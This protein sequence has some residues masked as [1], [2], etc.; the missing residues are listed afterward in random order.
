[1]TNEDWYGTTPAHWEAGNIRRFASMR[2]GHTPSRQHP[3]Y[4]TDCTI[5]WFTLADVWQLRAG[6]R[7]LGE[8]SEQ[9]S[10]LGLANSAAELLPAGTV[11]LSRTASV[12]FSGI[13]PVPMATSQDFWNWVPKPGMLSRFL[14]YQLQSMKPEFE[15]L[16]MGSTHRTIYQGDAASL[17]VVAPPLGEQRAIADY[18]DRETA[19]IDAFIAKNE[20]LIAL[21]TE[22]RAGVAQAGVE[23]HAGHGARLKYRFREIDVRAGGGWVD[24]PLLS[25]SIHRGVVPRDETPRFSDES[26]DLSH[27]KVA[28]LGD[29]VLNR[30]R[31][32]QGG[33]GVAPCAGLVSPDYAVLR[34]FDNVDAEW[35]AL[36]MRTP[37]FV[38][39]MVLRLRGIGSTDSGAVR[40]PRIGV[41]DVGAILID[42]PAAAVQ[43]AELQAVAASV[44]RIEAALTVARRGVELA[45][46]RR[47]A[48]I[49]A[50][51]TG[52]IDVGVAA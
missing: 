40:T 21:L 5:P 8:T 12:G 30:M 24:L 25:V 17:R 4:W 41:A 23:H 37:R 6:A 33:L 16:M 32:F 3:E 45:R 49:S 35:L 46:E 19:Q 43:R 27:Y 52:K 38:G 48:L 15:R 47:A 13:M 2:T 31:A 50:A 51:V 18:L 10:E 26:S 7:E 39:E 44:A 28:R 20:E 11:V 42:V 22:R 36:V 1:M 14:W 34:P 29:I 9:I